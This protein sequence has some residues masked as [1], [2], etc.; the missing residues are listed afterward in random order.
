V[1]QED[2]MEGTRELARWISAY[3]AAMA[4]ALMFLAT[5]L[6]GSGLPAALVRGV[7][8]AAA[9]LLIGRVLARAAVGTVLNAM[10]RDRAARDKGGRA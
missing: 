5:T 6:A 10:A 1:L 9:G 3:A 2:A 8:A 7:C 4:F